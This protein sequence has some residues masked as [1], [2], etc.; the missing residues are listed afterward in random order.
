MERVC[1]LLAIRLQGT[2]KN[3]GETEVREERKEGYCTSFL[4]LA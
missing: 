1:E 2:T 3:M 4:S